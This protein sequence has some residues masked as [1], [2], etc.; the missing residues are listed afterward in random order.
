MTSLS[1]CQNTSRAAIL[2]NVELVRAGCLGQTHLITAKMD[3]KFIVFVQNGRPS[4]TPLMT[5]RNITLQLEVISWKHFLSCQP[6]F[7]ERRRSAGNPFS[8]PAVFQWYLITH[9]NNYK[10]D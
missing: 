3:C 8:F 6:M 7:P 1:H 10:K 5:L 2:R 9:A 4:T